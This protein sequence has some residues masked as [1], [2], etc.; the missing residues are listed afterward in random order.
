MSDKNCTLH[1]LKQKL[2][3]TYRN[4]C[5]DQKLKPFF[6]SLPTT[7]FLLPTSYTSLENK[8]YNYIINCDYNR[9][10][11]YLLE[12]IKYDQTAT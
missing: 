2:I 5:C 11:L 4:A 10:I 3:E 7:Y 1:C 8:H 12:I 9:N 6:L